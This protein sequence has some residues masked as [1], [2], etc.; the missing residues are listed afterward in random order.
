MKIDQSFNRTQ[1]ENNLD[2]YNETNQDTHVGG[3]DAEERAKQMAEFCQQMQTC[4]KLGRVQ[5]KTR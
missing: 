1:Y 4:L 3:G 5:V 2:A